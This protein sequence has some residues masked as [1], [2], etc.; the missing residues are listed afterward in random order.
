MAT[1]TGYSNAEVKA[2]VFLTFCLAMFVAMLFSYG[3]VASLWRGRQEI[4]V[5]FTSVTA[6]RPDAPVRY[7][8]VEVGRV[9][10]IK[11]LHLD[12]NNVKLLPLLSIRDLDNLPLTDKEQKTLRNPN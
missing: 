3:K 9:R 6:L 5:V 2:G 10:E 1:S 8:G 11:I 4:S 7:N 12:E